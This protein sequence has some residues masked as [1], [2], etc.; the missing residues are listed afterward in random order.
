VELAGRPLLFWQLQTLAAAGVGDLAVVCGYQSEQVKALAE[1]GP[2]PFIAV[3]N[4]RWA[5]TNM[6]SSL[7]CAAE[8]A[9][10]EECLISYSDI[11]YSVRHVRALMGDSRPL[12]LTYDADW[13]RLWRF[14]NDGDPLLDAETFR[15]E[16]GLLRE[17]GA[18]PENLDQVRG[19]Y[20]GLLKLTSEGW[21]IWLERC[22]SLGSD[23]DH[24]DMTGF[25]RLM[26]ADGL[27]VGA[28]S[29]HGAWCEVDSDRDL[30]IYEKAL[31]AGTFSHD[32]R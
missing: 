9:G 1:T 21:K 27:A 25:L 31:T 10:G 16:G 22:D 11:V 5:D 3:E 2:T 12:A 8:W 15:E 17:I 23:V 13:E 32:W 18:R 24:I 4:S 29:V 19:Q 28:V 7:L 26:L 20:M 14:R 6:L 30:D